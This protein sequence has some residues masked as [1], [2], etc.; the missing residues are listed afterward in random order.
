M[1]FKSVSMDSKFFL[2]CM[3]RPLSVVLQSSCYIYMSFSKVTGSNWVSSDSR[4]YSVQFKAKMFETQ[5]QNAHF[6]K[7]NLKLP[8]KQKMACDKQRKKATKFIIKS[9]LEL[10]QIGTTCKKCFIFFFFFLVTAV[11]KKKHYS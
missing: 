6:S 11:K 3:N 8:P 2:S 9:W 1:N 10:N 7:A 4:L 5:S